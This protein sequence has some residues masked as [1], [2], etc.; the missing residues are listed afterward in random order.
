MNNKETT[1]VYLYKSEQEAYVSC[2]ILT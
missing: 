2:C 1:Q